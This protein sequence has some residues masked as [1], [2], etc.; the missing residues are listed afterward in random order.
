LIVRGVLRPGMTDC[1]WI[2]PVNFDSND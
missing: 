2:S 1:S